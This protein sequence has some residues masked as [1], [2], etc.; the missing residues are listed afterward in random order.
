MKLIDTI[1]LYELSKKEKDI[2]DSKSITFNHFINFLYQE[3]KV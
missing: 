2:N 1:E 3:Y